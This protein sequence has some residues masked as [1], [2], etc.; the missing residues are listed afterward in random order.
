MLNVKQ[1]IKYGEK[2]RPAELRQHMLIRCGSRFIRRSKIKNKTR[3]QSKQ[4]HGVGG[5]VGKNLGFVGLAGWAAVVLGVQL[6][7]P[8]RT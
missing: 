7:L 3:Q 4:T 6:W 5:W 1:I 2:N 8:I